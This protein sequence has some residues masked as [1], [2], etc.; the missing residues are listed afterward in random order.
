[1]P[2]FSW[3]K[4]LVDGCYGILFKISFIKKK[5]KIKEKFCSF[6]VPSVVYKLFEEYSN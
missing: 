1:M 5:K 6:E 4:R 2:V 3:R